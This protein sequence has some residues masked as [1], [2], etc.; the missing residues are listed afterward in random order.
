MEPLITPFTAFKFTEEEL[1][2]AR[3]LTIE[4][5]AYYQ[6]LLADA[7]A[8]KIAIEFDPEHPVLFAQREAYLRGQMDILNM[9]LGMTGSSGRPKRYE[10]VSNPAIPPQ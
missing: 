1:G 4:H 10:E 8:E 7:A 2:K 9:I 3:K 6:T 5:E